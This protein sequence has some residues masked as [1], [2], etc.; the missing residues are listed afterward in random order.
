MTRTDGLV[1]IP[2]EGAR[3]ELAHTAL[4]I[5]CRAVERGKSAAFIDGVCYAMRE[6]GFDAN[7]VRDIELA[8]N[9]AA[10]R[11]VFDAHRTGVCARCG[12]PLSRVHAMP[13]LW[14]VDD[15]LPV[16]TPAWIASLT[17]T[18]GYACPASDPDAHRR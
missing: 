3:E 1:L 10:M 9:D 18:C 5:A 13:N 4:V 17:W 14:S 8:A 11:L 12:E 7:H 15:T 2:E 6:L 16:A